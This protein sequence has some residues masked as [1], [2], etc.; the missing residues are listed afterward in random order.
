[1]MRVFVAGHTGMAG[2]AI[3]RALEA[4]PIMEPVVVEERVDFRDQEATRRT[5]FDLAPDAVVVAA[6]KVGGI[7]ANTTSRVAFSL[8]NTLISTNLIASAHS[9]GVS[10]LVNLSSSCVYPRHC[11]QPMRETSLLTGSLEPTNQ[12]Y[13]LAK[14]NA[15]ELVE[16]YQECCEYDYISLIPPNLFGYG[17]NFCLVE[18][19]F[20]P[21]A[22]HKVWAASRKADRTASFWGTGSVMR[23]F[24]FAD[25]LGSAVVHFLDYNNVKSLGS[26]VN[27]GPGVE[28]SL[29][30]AASVIAKR[31]E[32]EVR[33]DQ[34]TELE[35]M[36]RKV[37]DSSLA[38]STGWHPRVPFETGVEW[39]WDWLHSTDLQSIRLGSCSPL[40]KP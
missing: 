5:M 22:F 21:A 19:H 18:G 38:H 4:N 1:M 27:V 12:P 36:P 32:V 35:G 34:Q 10:R 28:M 17:D 7:L 15:M 26:A 23:E 37:M 2:S 8:D 20:V 24:M 16:A 33:F 3:V 13:A 9:A 11:Q 30:R 31:M 29:K 39:V 14:L 6:A 25:D 40:L